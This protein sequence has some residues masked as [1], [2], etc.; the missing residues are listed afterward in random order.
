MGTWTAIEIAESRAWSIQMPGSESTVDLHYLVQ[1]AP[2]S[3]ADVYPGEAGLLS[4][5]PTVRQRLPSGVY[6]SNA[7]FKQ[8]V[9]R[10][11]DSTIVRDAPYTWRVVCRFSAIQAADGTHVAVTRQSGTRQAN[12][13]R[14]AP[15]IPSNGD[16]TW[17]TGVVDIGG[18]KVDQAGN[19]VT[20]EIPQMQISVEVLWDRTA[21]AAA[22]TVGEPPTSTFASY[23]GTRNDAA[24]LGC[25][26]G[27]LVYRGFTISPN[28]EYYRIQHQ[29]LWDQMFHLEQIALP[30][31]DGAPVCETIVN[32]AGVDVLQCTKVGFFQKYPSKTTHSTLLGT[33]NLSELTNPVPGAI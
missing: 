4:A 21:Q 32:I 27:T 23:I 33:A 24:F 31:P 25:A 5:V 12:I 10:S 22:N 7:Y 15:T 6:G 1:W 8:F 19:P 3:P 30:M 9:C 2:T 28:Y 26:I 11:V 14:I 20:Y 29:W 16:V 13:F 17:P 18:T